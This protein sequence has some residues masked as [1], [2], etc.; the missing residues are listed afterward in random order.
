MEIRKIAV[1]GAGTMGSQ[2]AM[3]AAIQ[4][5]EV[6]V[7]DTKPEMREKMEAFRVEYLAGRKN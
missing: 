7:T 1:I 2:I 4:G 3:N 6:K 5:F